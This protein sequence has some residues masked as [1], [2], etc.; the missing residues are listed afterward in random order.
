MMNSVFGARIRPEEAHPLSRLLIRAYEPALK[1]ALRHKTL[2]AAMVLIAAAVTVPVYRRLGAEFVPP[3]DEGVLLYM[4]STAPGI[5]VTEAKRLLQLTD[6]RL[7][8]Q[9]EVARV[10]GKAG[11]A[12]TATDAAPLS[13]LET[14]VVLKPRQQWPRQIPLPELIARFDASLRFPGVANTWTMPVR[15]RIDMLAT[16]MRTPLGL[17]IAGSDLERIQELGIRV[18]NLLRGIRGTRS[19]FAERI[20]EGRYIDVQW[21]RGELARAGISMEGAQSAVQYAIGG[22]SVSTAIQGRARYPVNVRLPQDSRDNLDALRQ[23]LVD[24]SIGGDPVALEQLAAVRV[25]QGP[26]MIRDEDGMITAYVYLDL[27]GRD[28][29]AYIAEASEVLARCLSVPAGYTVA[30]SGQYDAFRRLNRRLLQVVPLT[31]VIVAVLLYWSTRSAAKTCL[32]LLAVPFSAIGA[33]WSLWMLGYPMSPAVW[34]GLIALL[35]VDAETGTFM[36]L[37]LDLAWQKRLAEG[38]MR[39]HSDLREAV[40][41]GAVRR[42]RPKFMTVSTMF[43][44]LL[45]L[46]WSTRAGAEVMKRIAAPMIGGLATSFLMELIVYPILY[47]WWRSRTSPVVMSA[48]ESPVGVGD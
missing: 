5:S 14:I 7:K 16:G 6:A 24:S 32:V 42:I 31:L 40:L 47:E 13:M 30:W 4:P 20:N 26:A 23:V 19:I 15:G 27:D 10:L 1:Y 48:Q 3:L 18:E 39:T 12:E 35:G 17:K 37:Y 11:R 43:L 9:P 36:V 25:V 41:A 2:V 8:S 21:D 28:P 38:R 44:G 34:V 22:E 45:P 29:A 46:L 33:I